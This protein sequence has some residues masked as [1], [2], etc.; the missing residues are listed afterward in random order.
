MPKPSNDDSA[1][2]VRKSK[3]PSLLF[4]L[5]LAGSVFFFSVRYLL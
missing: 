1:P 4:K 2:I 3:L 5:L